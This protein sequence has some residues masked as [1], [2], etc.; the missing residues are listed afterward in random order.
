MSW[1]IAQLAKNEIFVFFFRLKNSP[2]KVFFT[3]FNQ[4]CVTERTCVQRDRLSGYKMALER[5]GLGFL[6]GFLA[7]QV[8]CCRDGEEEFRILRSL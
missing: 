7:K 8:L 3:S 1:F 4:K 6:C 5:L 2:I